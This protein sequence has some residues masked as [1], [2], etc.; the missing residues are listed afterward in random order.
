MFIGQEELRLHVSDLECRCY[1]Q[2]KEIDKL[3]EAL[4][5]SEEKV[6]YLSVSCFVLEIFF[7]PSCIYICTSPVNLFGHD[8]YEHYYLYFTF[9]L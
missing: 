9:E 1:Q 6:L 7:L 2:Q 5:A 4:R 3:R 8:L